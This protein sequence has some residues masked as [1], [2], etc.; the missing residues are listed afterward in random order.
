M[1]HLLALFA[2]V[3]L[4]FGCSRPSQTPHTN[5][6]ADVE[7]KTVALV[8][9]EDNEARAFCS[10]VWVGEDEILTAAHC[11]SDQEIGDAIDYVTRGDLSANDGDELE[12]LRIAKLDA[13]D[14]DRDL[15]L[16][17]VKFAPAHPIPRVASTVTV[18]QPTQ[19]MGHPLGLWWSYSTGSVS[20]LRFG[21][22]ILPIPA[23]WVQTTAPISPGN[24]GGGLFDADGNLLGICHGSATRGQNLNL[25]VHAD[26]VRAF[27]AAHAKH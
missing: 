9:A 26:Y 21:T 23:W 14:E 13:R 16:L 20:A 1:K 8:Q 2:L 17:R 7:Q 25:Y 27:L 15:A 4:S 18:G 6:S 11:V 22:F 3:L 5:A 10:G 19:T 24:S 12:T